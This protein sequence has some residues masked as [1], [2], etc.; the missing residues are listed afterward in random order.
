M[1]LALPQ[2]AAE[3]QREQHRAKAELW[4]RG[5]LSWKFQDYPWA[6][7]LHTFIRS[8]WGEAPHLD[9]M[10]H[11]RGTKSTTCLAVGIEECIRHDGV[12]TAVLCTTKDQARAVCEESMEA[13]LADCPDAIRP[14]LIKNDFTFEFDHNGS[15]IVIL[16]ADKL[17]KNSGRGRKFRFIHVMEAA[18][19]PGLKGILRKVLAP[20]LLDVLGKAR[21][22]MVLESTPP[23]EE[24]AEEDA[25]YW[26]TVWTA[27]RSDGR[28][29]FL[30][31][32]KNAGAS[33]VFKAEC[34]A[35]Y[36][37]NAEDPD[38]LREMELRMD[39]KSSLTAIPEATE[40]ALYSEHPLAKDS[41]VML[42]PVVREVP[43]PAGADKYEGLDPGGTHPTGELWGFYDFENNLL[44]I[45]DEWLLAGARTDQIAATTRERELALWG[46]Q[47]TGKII[48]VADNDNVTLLID[49][50][51]SHKLVFYPTRK[52]DKDAQINMTRVMFRNGQIAIHPRCK[53]LIKTLRIA[54]RAKAKKRGFEEMKEIGHADLLDT[55]LYIVRNLRKHA[56]PE[57]PQPS[58]PTAFT[59]P[60][61][62]EPARPSIAKKFSRA[63]FGRGLRKW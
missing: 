22:A 14:R 13:I 38:Y 53:L 19:I 39:I 8:K 26:T 61:P 46:E 6:R 59:Q 55:L 20:T 35:L 58:S 1:T 62:P 25:A 63:A 9:V 43:M 60:A 37:G 52:D 5:E 31:L 41:T 18:F 36:E 40:E 42:P 24:V 10:I 27:A 3:L 32:S 17:N 28:A 2:T 23:D 4:R 16:S 45:Q 47:P 11:R 33:P 7:E 56:M 54:K 57:P 44:V 12:S 48:R 15:R 49:L 51:H 29:F 50:N 21:G 34:L 30:P